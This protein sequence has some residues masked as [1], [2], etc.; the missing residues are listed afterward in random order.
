M[1]KKARIEKG[2]VDFDDKL[3]CLKDLFGGSSNFEF[4][5]NLLKDLPQDLNFYN[6]TAKQL[7]DSFKSWRIGHHDPT[8]DAGLTFR[9]VTVHRLKKLG[10]TAP[11]LDEILWHGTI[12]DFYRIL[13]T[14]S[15]S[16]RTQKLRTQRDSVH[17]DMVTIRT[18]TDTDGLSVKRCYDRG[19]MDQRLMYAAPDAAETWQGVAIADTYKQYR[20]CSEALEVFLN[21]E[22][23]AEF[24]AQRQ[25]DSAVSFGAGS[26]SKDIKI[27]ESL[28]QLTDTPSEDLIYT[29]VDYSYS[30]LADTEVTIRKNFEKE[31]GTCRIKVEALRKD[32][33]DLRIWPQLRR[34]G[35]PIAWFINGGTIG[36]INESDFLYSVQRMAEPGDWL[37]ISMDTVS[38]DEVQPE[39]REDLY[40]EL[41]IQ[42]DQDYLR[43]LLRPSLA[44]VWP[45]SNHTIPFERALK[46]I[47]VDI[48]DGKKRRYSAVENSLSVEFSTISN[49]KVVLLASTRY[50]EQT[51]IDFASGDGF[52]HQGSFPS[53][54]DQ[55]YKILAFE[56]GG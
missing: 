2:I 14:N 50:H 54:K 23:W 15:I 31:D 29:I 16:S 28:L 56:F 42:Y 52:N 11:N 36:N 13:P 25:P 12:Q 46:E 44:A 45:Y 33:M 49:K 26:A 51:F 35:T 55:G 32:F 21:S 53:P 1:E 43:E 19:V 3:M 6:V 4:A 41:K 47:K 20:N 22:V 8:G 30:M 17:P 40:R 38:E 7:A 18:P 5:T 39:N 48:V 27:I 34:E 24:C 9:R 37:M 10:C